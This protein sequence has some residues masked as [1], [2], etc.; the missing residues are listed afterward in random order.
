MMPLCCF[1]SNILPS[2]SFW[3]MEKFVKM[4]AFTLLLQLPGG[5]GVYRFTSSWVC[6]REA[7]GFLEKVVC[8]ALAEFLTTLKKMQGLHTQTRFWK[9]NNSWVY[10]NSWGFFLV[11]FKARVSGRTRFPWTVLREV[12]CAFSAVWT[13]QIQFRSACCVLFGVTFAI[14]TK[15]GAQPDTSLLYPL[16]TLQV[17]GRSVRP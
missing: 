5:G 13:S 1:I 3:F 15:T 7:E 8:V 12:P 16:L 4:V 17:Q 6:S 2:K 9:E 14:L 11:C 10:S